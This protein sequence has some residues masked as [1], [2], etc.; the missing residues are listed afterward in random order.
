MSE[1]KEEKNELVEEPQLEKRPASDS[2]SS[3]KRRRFVSRRNFAIL[4]GCLAIL[5]VSI[6]ALIF[7]LFRTGYVDGYVKEQF[8]VA[9]DEMGIGFTAE[10]FKMGVAPLDLTLKNAVFINKKTGEKIFRIE[11]AKLDMTVLDLYELKTERNIDVTATEV[12]GFE[13]WVSFDEEGNSNF[14]G[15]ELLPPK[16]VVKFQYASTVLSLRNGLVHFG[17][18]TRKI[19]GDA[20]NLVFLMEPENFDV[21]DD[22]KRYKF[23]LTST[24]STFTYD[25]SKVD[26]VN[27]RAVGVADG[28]GAE[29]TEFKLT[30]PVGTAIVSGNI[31]DWKAFKYDFKIT[32]TIDLT[33]TSDTFPIGTALRG[34]GNFAGTITGEGENYKIDGE[35]TSENLAAANIRLKALKVNA[36]INGKSSVYEGQG[37]AVAEMLTFEDFIIDYPQLVGNIRGTGTDFRWFGELRAVA[38]KTSFGTIAGLYISDADAEYRDGK[39]NAKLKNFRAE[40]FSSVG[41]KIQSLQVSGATISSENGAINA[42]LPSASAAKVDVQGATLHGVNVRNAKLKNRDAGTTIDAGDVRIDRLET[43]DARLR[44]VTAK[45]VLVNNRGG[46]T[47]ATA[48]NVQSDG[49]DTRGAKIGNINASGVDV[50]IVGN[51]TKVYSNNLKVAKI[52]TDSAVLGSLNVAGVRLTVRDGRIEGTTGDFD[53]GTIALP[54]TGKLENVKVKSPVFVLEP[55]GRYRAS[56]DMSLGGGILGSIRLGAARAAVVANND[57]IELNNLSANVMDGKIDGNASIATSQRSRSSVKADFSNLDISK[58]LA[59]QGGNVIPI[60]GQTTGKVDLSFNG[61]DLKRASGNLTADIDAN[62]GSDDRGLIPLAGK[63]GVT[64]TNGLFNIDFANLNTA[65]SQLDATGRFDLNGNDSNLNIALDSSDASEIERIFRVLNLSDSVEQQLDNYQA[66]FA[67][68]LVFKGTLTGNISDPMLDGRASLESIILRGRDLGSLASDINATSYGFELRNGILQERD[69]GKLTF[70]VSAPNSGTN[71]IAVRANLD[72]IDLGSLLSALAIDSIPESLRNMEAETSGD[73]NLKGLPNDMQGE[74]NI[75]AR[76]GSVKGQSFDSLESKVLFQGTLVNVEKFEAK[77]G[78]GFLN[79][80]GT[81]ETNT[82][83]FNFEADG[84]D[85]PVS[86]IVAFFPDNPS[87]PDIEGVVNVKATAIGNASDTSSFDVNFNGVGKGI[88]INQNSFGDVNFEGKTENR[89]LNAN[90]TTRFQGQNQLITASVNFADPNVP[91]KAQTTFNKSR[92]DPYIAIFRKPEPGAIEFSGVATGGVFIEG[93]LTKVNDEGKRVFTSEFLEGN[94][95]FSQF[96]LLIGETPLNAIEPID[97]RFSMNEVSIASAKFAGGGSNVVVSGTKAFNDNG[98]NN[99][100]VDGRIDLRIMNALSKNMFFSGFADVAM[101]LTGVNKN[102]RLNG[103]ASIENASAS[104]FVGSERITFER[105]KGSMIFTTNQVQIQQLTGFLG[106]GKIVATGGAQ[107]KGLQLDRYRVE[108]QGNNITARIPKDFITTGNAEIEI[109]GRRSGGELDTLISGT[110]YAKRSVY[111]K[112]IDL[113]DFISGRREASLS[114]GS[115][116]TSV[117]GVPK[118][119]IRVIGRNAF[120]ARN[121][122]A[123][124]TASADLRITG[125]IEYP[126]ISGRITANSGTLIFRDDRYEIQRAVLTFPPNATT[127][128]PLINLQAETQINGYQIFV[129]LN[130]VLTDTESLS[131]TLRSNPSLPQGDVVSL[132]TTGSLANSGGGIPTYAQSGIN[133][134]AEILADEIINKPISKATDRLFGLNKFALDPIISGERSNPTARLTVGRQINRNLLV[135]YSTNLAEDQNQVLALEYRVSNKLSFIAKYEQRSLTN[136][137]KNR[138]NFAFEIRLRKRF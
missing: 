137:T 3:R 22:K 64:A 30:S 124:L 74:A 129:S 18:T 24:E 133:T 109:N 75:V 102:S 42:N 91:L 83:N 106:G 11:N 110:F 119:D 86:R 7:A 62:A 134:A 36:A 97:V 115:S 65:K 54:G 108:I 17:E 37:K 111:N 126:L 5:T 43:E 31:K 136:V 4:V 112:D 67:G 85:V 121:N 80:K 120:H 53:A 123:D 77:F 70:D 76:N 94:A 47:E 34:F 10:T 107:L 135:T 15:I 113:A 59:L 51:E 88:V 9:F 44:N 101:R 2:P 8:V 104:T 100:S 1:E 116:G 98:V 103:N 29:I 95:Q 38:A 130:G 56:L 27:I 90:V 21:P 122:I 132:I 58:L 114:Q 68:A 41:A 50:R 20:K 99:L 19:S 14:K 105:L 81:Y 125:D 127:I 13:V 79:G 57:R 138:N 35:I 84:K 25:E 39:L 72:K 87:I 69:G 82:S 28:S 71:N 63:L 61:T 118:L 78:T 40:N 12:N 131:A 26:P 92:L 33:R 73:L 96:D 128:E 93:N 55:S 66:E 52:T 49:V 45:N 32:S 48:S 23:D 16:N 60:E 6:A 46:V 117:I 89:I